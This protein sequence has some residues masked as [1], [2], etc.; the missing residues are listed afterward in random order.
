MFKLISVIFI[1]SATIMIVIEYNKLYLCQNEFT[2][3]CIKAFEYILSIVSY[4]RLFLAEA[5]QRA[6]HIAGRAES[7]L[8]LCSESIEN[9][10]PADKAF[11]DAI[12]I[13]ENCSEECFVILKDYFVNAGMM[14]VEIEIGKLNSLIEK[15]KISDEKQRKHIS[16]TVKQNI[17]LILAVAAAICICVI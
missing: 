15:L 7:F 16:N 12:S 10:I 17:K 14:N 6:A 5:M 9:N 13:Q 3:G 4:E 2:S 1:I 8:V 11:E